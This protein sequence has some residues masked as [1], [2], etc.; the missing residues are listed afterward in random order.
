MGEGWEGVIFSS[1]PNRDM[2]KYTVE[3]EC[4]VCCMRITPTQTL[5]HRGEGFSLAG[6]PPS[7]AEFRSRLKSI[8]RAAQPHVS[9]YQSFRKASVLSQPV[10]VARKFFA[11][12]DTA[13][14]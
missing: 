2:E 13:G 3:S 9:R 6:D 1:R 4:S 11:S 12:P 10:I 7:R 14:R 8:T 5:P